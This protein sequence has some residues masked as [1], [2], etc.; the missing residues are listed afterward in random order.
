MC[1]YVKGACREV[2]HHQARPELQ[3]PRGTRCSGGPSESST[4]RPTPLT[5]LAAAPQEHPLGPAVSL[6]HSLLRRSHRAHREGKML[7]GVLSITTERA[8]THEFGAKTQ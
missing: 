3:G 5:H 8:L 4:V 6:Q 1:V 2:G 7:E